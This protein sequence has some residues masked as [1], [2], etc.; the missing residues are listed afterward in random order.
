[1]PVPLSFG[2]ERRVTRMRSKALRTLGYGVIAF[3][4][5]AAGFPGLVRADIPGELK[6]LENRLEELDQQTSQLRGRYVQPLEQR[7]ERYFEHRMERG[8]FLYKDGDYVH[9]AVIF[10]DL[11]DYPGVQQRPEYY[12]LLWF[13]GDSYYF[14]KNFIS[15]K[16]KL[17]QVVAYGENQPHFREAIIRLIQISVNLGRFEEAEAYYAKMSAAHNTE[18]WDIIQYAY[19]KSLYRQGDLDRAYRTF[20]QIPEKSSW[21]PQAD[22]FRGTILVQKGQL[23]EAMPLFENLK[24][25]PESDESMTTIRELA[26]LAVSR[27]HFE[28]ANRLLIKVATANKSEKTDYEAEAWR[29]YGEALT[30]Y[31]LIPVKSKLFDEAYYEITWIHIQKKKYAEAANTLDMLLFSFP[32]SL[33]APDSQV[34]KG[35]I[36]LWEGKY[37]DARN[38][39]KTV[40]NK[41]AGVV[42]TMDRILKESAGKRAEEIQQHVLGNDATLPPIVVNWL[43]K[44]EDVAHALSLGKEIDAS[45]KDAEESVKA[46]ETLKVHLD[47][48]SKANLFPPLKEGREKGVELEHALTDLRAKLMTLGNLLVGD[49]ISEAD[50]KRLAEVQSRRRDLEALYAKLPKTVQERLARR[51]R[52]IAQVEELD[53][54]VY[55]IKLKMKALEDVINDIMQRHEQLRGDPTMSAKYLDEVK[56]KVAQEQNVLMAMLTQIEDL[57][58]EMAGQAERMKI[59]DEAGQQD[60]RIRHELEKALSEEKELLDR[61]RNVLSAEE[62]A[63]LDRIETAKGRSDKMDGVI[64]FFFRDLEDLV[65]D[66]VAEFKRQVERE[67]QDLQVY[68]Q[69]IEKYKASSSQLAAE[70]AYHNLQTVHDH[71]YDVVLKANVGLVDIAWEHREKYRNQIENLLERRSQ[72]KEQLNE[73]F[74]DLKGE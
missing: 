51:M 27:I 46:I 15:A 17:D 69:E 11:F 52:H 67:G 73:S 62:I 6:G 37:D 35:N 63:L 2:V 40:I 64:Q 16:T 60:E 50:R 61:M 18:G 34:L 24:K 39:F 66:R 41:Y 33:Y 53:K 28:R 20:S 65:A 8:L 29:E 32:E 30:G 71:F 12:D 31:R 55:G 43:V 36:M 3:F 70:I 21:R 49:R 19:A 13:S 48:E 57:S 56:E 47:Q 54:E 72:E 58:K 1:M 5:T 44:E 42:D 14:N 22:Y 38:S 45:Q 25:I 10:S 9:S 26:I 74:Q 4:L 59:G 23:D 7:K 68:L